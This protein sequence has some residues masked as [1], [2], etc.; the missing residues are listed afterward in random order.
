VLAVGCM[1][2]AL[3]SLAKPTDDRFENRKKTEEGNRRKNKYNQK[4]NEEFLNGVQ[5]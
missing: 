4:D 2:S 3:S 5:K 1:W